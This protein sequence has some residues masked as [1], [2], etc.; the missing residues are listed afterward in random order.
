MKKFLLFLGLL[1]IGNCVFAQTIIVES[2]VNMDNFWTKNGKDAQ[3]VL[4]VSKN[5][6]HANELNRATVIVERTWKTPKCSSN[7]YKKNIVI[8][9]G[10][11][12]YID[13]DDELAYILAHELALIQE[14]YNG[15]LKLLAMSCNSKKYKSKADVKA[16][17]YMVKAGYNPISAIIMGN[18]IFEEP[19]WDWGFTSTAPKGSKRLISM[20]KYIYKRYPSFLNS[21]LAKTSDFQNILKENKKFISAFEQKQKVKNRIGDL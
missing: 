11:L 9:V 7:T 18:K 4:N 10:M 2:G 13:N 12:P 1:L 21:N 16:I 3:K 20:Y 8:N 6:I 17:D 15:G 19:L 5:L 14:S